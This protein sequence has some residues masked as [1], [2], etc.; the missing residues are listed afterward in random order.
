M[1]RVQFRSIG[2]FHSPRLITLA[3]LLLAGILAVGSVRAEHPSIFLMDKDGEEINPILGENADQPF[4]TAATCGMCHDYE[5]I[6]SGYHFQM[7]WDVVSDDFGVD[8]GKPWQISDGMMGKWCPMYLRQPA[9]KSNS[10]ADEIDLTVYDFV[11]RATASGSDLSCGSC[12]PGG[13]G[14]EFDRDGNRYD[15]TLIE[16]PEL[17]E[18]LDGDYYQSQ[19]DRSGV[20]EADCF[21][22]HLEG[23][24]FLERAYQLSLGNYRW[25]VV[26]GTGFG[27]VDGVV[28]RGQQ[29]SVTYNTRFFNADGSISP[30]MSWPPPDDNCVFC[31]G[32]SDARKRGFSWNDPYNPDV[33]NN[34]GVSCTACHPSG[35][36]HQFAKGHASD[37]R[38]AD[39]L[40]GTVKT[41]RECHQEGLL[42]ATIPHHETIRP[43]H[44]ERIACEACHIP[45]LGRAA[46]LGFDATTGEH[47]VTTNPMTA[48]ALGERAQWRPIYER[49]DN[50]RIYPFNGLLLTWW[51]N[52]VDTVLY[53]LWL[54]EHAAG[55]ELFSDQ[56]TDDNDDG[57]AEVNRPEEIIAGLKAFSASL[58]GNERF[59]QIHP[60][61]VK[62]GSAYHLDDSGQLATLEYEPGPCTNYSISHNVAPARMALG[63]NGCDDCHTPQAHF[64]KGQ[65]ILDFCDENGRQVT[66]SNGRYYGCNP[67]AFA[68]NS[69]HQQVLS[70]IV[71]VSII[72]V[73]FLITLHYHSYGPKH[74]SFV[75]DSGEVLRFTF[76]ERAVHLL[77]L[78]SFV[79]LAITGLIMAFNWT[80]W[81]H[82]L[83]SSQK[84]MLQTHIWS[85]VVFIVTTL[86][87][88]KL[89][90][91][92]AL[93]ASYDKQ[94]V[95]R[96][97]GYL[98]YKGEVPSGRFNAGQKAFY[99]Y[100]TVFGLLISITGVLL[101]FKLEFVLSVIC[102]TSTIHNLLA[103]VL[104]A[105]V[106]SH[107][108]LGT[109]AN[110]G[111][112]RVLI[113]GFVS[114]TWAKHHHPNW[115]Q[116]LVDRGILDRDKATDHD[117]N[118]DIDSSEE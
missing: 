90:L 54:R 49:W 5:E 116:M 71:S 31:H 110:P 29:P 109:I 105:G 89:W 66:V 74:I 77:R 70:P 106:M 64:F 13:G 94:W 87:G 6:T 67:L 16:N 19:W 72:I 56:V 112:W 22:C 69:F 68:I 53:P 107:A 42:G 27:I 8:E 4:S 9:K 76:V 60:V 45:T 115:Y 99:W 34:Q 73:I 114:R 33:H 113:D 46:A 18:E 10:S 15:E 35:P 55:W 17:R 57:I 78:L 40:D 24:N 86:A 92:D 25:A 2:K 32:Q 97:G 28:N 63:A 59:T 41:C 30:E 36:D 1:P 83:F 118:K 101:I 61:L 98:G 51:G 43:S 3:G 91:R 11:G 62:G 96:L 50:D 12:H 80:N 52:L 81:M 65:R 47:V 88:L 82:L 38:V 117:E 95:R 93:F 111:T 21:I 84:Q 58:A 85:G 102:I 20:V 75:P 26:S 104:I 103:F 14:L 108:Y 44:L 100:T 48:T 37:L 7:G 79:I 39:S 23:Y